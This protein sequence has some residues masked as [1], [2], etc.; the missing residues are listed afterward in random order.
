MALGWKE[1]LP[2]YI[3]LLTR[4][5]GMNEGVPKVTEATCCFCTQVR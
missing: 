1:V 4:F 5:L 3:C 2:R